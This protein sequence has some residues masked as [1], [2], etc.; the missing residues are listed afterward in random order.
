[1]ATPAHSYTRT[2]LDEWFRDAAPPTPDD[3]SVLADGRRLDTP[4]KVIAFLDEV[5][6]EYPD[7][8]EGLDL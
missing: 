6:R 1:M 2:E 3:V 8:V 4:E 7:D 5:R